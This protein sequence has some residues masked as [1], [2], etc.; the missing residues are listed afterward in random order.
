MQLEH[1][2]VPQSFYILF[3]HFNDWAMDVTSCRPCLL[4]HGFHILID[5]HRRTQVFHHG[6]KSRSIGWSTRA[7]A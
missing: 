3:D 1:K 4:C 5:T 7:H 6:S 2:A